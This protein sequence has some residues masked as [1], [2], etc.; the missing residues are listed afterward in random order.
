M[1]GFQSQPGITIADLDVEILVMHS[2]SSLAVLTP[3]F[4]DTREERG[5]RRRVRLSPDDFPARGWEINNRPEAP[6]TYAVI[7]G[8]SSTNTSGAPDTQSSHRK[9][10]YAAA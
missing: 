5:F 4:T 6:A 9:A 8:C 1:V 3:I 10:N 2:N 7:S